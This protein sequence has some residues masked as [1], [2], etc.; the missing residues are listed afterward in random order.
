MGGCR[1]VILFMQINK[2]SRPSYRGRHTMVNRW[3]T[4]G[5]WILRLICMGQGRVARYVNPK[6]NFDGALRQRSRTPLVI[7]QNVWLFSIIYSTVTGYYYDI[8]PVPR[9]CGRLD[10]GRNTP[11]PVSFVSAVF[12]I[13]SARR[14]RRPPGRP[15][16]LCPITM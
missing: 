2:N 16:W 1:V 13:C 14:L 9:P 15:P 10:T 4:R 12:G 7:F 8:V 3:C 11:W 5:F 6:G